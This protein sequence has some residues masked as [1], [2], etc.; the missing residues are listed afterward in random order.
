VPIDH[1]DTQIIALL[2]ANARRGPV[3]LSAALGVTRNTVQAR[4]RRLEES[5]IIDG[6]TP[7]IA[8]HQ[9]GIGVEAFAALALHQGRLDQVVSALSTIPHV[10]EVHATTG[11]EDLLIRVAAQDNASLQILIQQIV[12]IPGVAHSNTTLCLSTPLPYRV[13]PLLDAETRA[14]GWGRSTPRPDIGVGAI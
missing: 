2:S 8:L 13:Q 14:S 7:R 10:L 5:G 4:I 9:A 3:D 1:L 11:R 6:F 12:A